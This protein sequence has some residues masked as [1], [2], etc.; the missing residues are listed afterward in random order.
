MKRG[1]T[2]LRL[3][4]SSKSLEQF[5]NSYP[6]LELQLKDE[7]DQKRLPTLSQRLEYNQI[8]F[9]FCKEH[10]R[11]IYGG[12]AA[13]KLIKSKDE[14]D[15]FYPEGDPADIDFYS[16]EPI[17]DAMKLANIFEKRGFNY[18]TA[19]EAQHAETYTVFV[20][21]INV[22]DISYVPANIY[23]RIPFML[24]D[25]LHFAGPH[26]I[27]IDMLRMFNDPL[28]SGELRWKK[29]FPR[30]VL[31][32]KH[33][34]FK[35]VNAPLKQ[36]T[37]DSK[38]SL[39]VLSKILNELFM[40][41]KKRDSLILF[42]DY[43]YNY[44]SRNTDNNMIKIVRYEMISTNYVTDGKDLLA[45]LKEKFPEESKEFTTVE[46]YPLW[47]FLDYSIDVMY[48]GHK[49]LTLV[50]H[51]KKCIPVLNVDSV[52][53]KLDNSEEKTIGKINVAT[54]NLN[55]QMLLMYRFKMYVNKDDESYK[56]ASNM[57]SKL[58]EMRNDYLKKHKQTV[59]D[60]TL[61]KEFQVK[62]IGK[63]ED[64]MRDTRIERG[65][66][67][68]AGKVIVWKYQPEK[69]LKEPMSDYKFANTSGNAIRKSKNYKIA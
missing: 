67:A 32:Q 29:T 30:Y 36:P 65:H 68:K 5:D 8:V 47:Q 20:D 13:N 4:D 69:G 33:Y 19:Q 1:N 16:P 22:A 17:L 59:F 55:L 18:I 52:L 10:K 39:I 27:M 9:D 58:I 50:G 11:K 63:A 44:Y 57:L 25:G 43:A 15:A 49:F 34:P 35:S 64:P 48:R 12:F 61:F 3:Y 54:F 53:F 46:Y 37:V 21:Y 66:K 28:M 24:I 56:N 23:H 6:K 2:D 31:M 41:T 38:I 40:F 60:D 26:F 45:Y 7:S 62:C 42:G 14:K 51:N